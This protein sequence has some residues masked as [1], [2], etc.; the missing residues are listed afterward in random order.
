M[1]SPAIGPQ[2]QTY[3]SIRSVLHVSR[4]EGATH[5]V[6][7]YQQGA[8][9]RHINFHLCSINI[10]FSCHLGL[11]MVFLGKLVAVLPLV[12]TSGCPGVQVMILLLLQRIRLVG[13]LY[14]G[15]LAVCQ[16][17]VGSKVSHRTIA[18]PLD[19]TYGESNSAVCL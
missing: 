13:C 10:N 3:A 2:R 12:A 14:L 6:R 11:G 1:E 17:V 15:A 5:I 8:V 19:T 9:R 7:A 18:G 4:G 16:V